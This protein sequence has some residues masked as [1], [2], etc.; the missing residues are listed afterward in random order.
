MKFKITNLCCLVS[1]ILTITFTSTYA[2]AASSD[3]DQIYQ[4]LK[5]KTIENYNVIE[6]PLMNDQT[7]FNMTSSD[8]IKKIDFETGL[9]G[10]S[11]DYKKMNGISENNLKDN[12]D[13]TIVKNSLFYFPVKVSNKVVGIVKISKENN[14]YTVL[15]MGSADEIVDNINKAKEIIAKKHKNQSYNISY[16]SPNPY[17]TGFR[18]KTIDDDYFILTSD[19]EIGNMKKLQSDSIDNSLKRLKIKSKEIVESSANNNI[20]SPMTN[21]PNKSSL[22]YFYIALGFVII[23]GITMYQLRKRKLSKNAVE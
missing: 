22:N 21:A 19:S 3:V 12:I 10:Y 1:M 4:L 17:F 11:I 6:T 7:H 13:T 16:I 14:K 23:V 9:E 8:D 2:L 20:G 18:V 15:S 5:N